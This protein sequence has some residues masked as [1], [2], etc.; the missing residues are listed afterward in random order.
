[1]QCIIIC[2]PTPETE[3]D[4]TPDDIVYGPF[5]NENVACDWAFIHLP[6]YSW[7]WLPLTDPTLHR[8]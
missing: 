6:L 8:S 3:H 7:Y 1:M 4:A 2:T 5:P